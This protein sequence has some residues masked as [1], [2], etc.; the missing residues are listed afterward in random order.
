MYVTSQT[1]TSVTLPV[2]SGAEAADDPSHRVDCDGF[3]T[4]S[5]PHGHHD[6]TVV[7][8]PKENLA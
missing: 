3:Q 8:Y 6:V 4:G 2:A 1:V 5:P 7:T